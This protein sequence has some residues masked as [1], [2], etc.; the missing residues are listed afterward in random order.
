MLH[1]MHD[2]RYLLFVHHED[3]PTHVQVFNQY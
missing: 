2:S 1:N 3:E